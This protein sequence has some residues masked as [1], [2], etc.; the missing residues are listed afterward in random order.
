MRSAG[1]ASTPTQPASFTSR[2]TA[3]NFPMCAKYCSRAL[4]GMQK[5]N[6]TWLDYKHHPLKKSARAWHHHK[7]TRAV[8][9]NE[10][11]DLCCQ[12]IIHNSLVHKGNLPRKKHTFYWAFPKFGPSPKER[13]Y[14]FF[15][16]GFPNE[17]HQLTE[18][19]I[20]PSVRDPLISN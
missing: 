8:F 5:S 18:Q 19:E 6:V 3:C 1:S 9:L 13:V 7:V 20:M 2:M 12:T 15:W 11:L 16:E 14:F 4:I 17:E 10:V